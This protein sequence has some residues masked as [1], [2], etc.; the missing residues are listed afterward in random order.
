MP[1]GWRGWWDILGGLVPASGAVFAV[2]RTP[3][4]STCFVVSGDSLPRPR[5]RRREQ[6]LGGWWRDQLAANQAF[7]VMR[8]GAIQ[9]AHLFVAGSD[10]KTLPPRGP[11][12]YRAAGEAG[13]PHRRDPTGRRVT[14]VSRAPNKLDAFISARRSLRLRGRWREQRPLGRM[15]ADRRSRGRYRAPVQW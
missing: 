10:S 5:R 15:M 7:T 11:R 3:T 1:G 6:R 13:G 12:T 2:A 4:S 14:P 8:C 9:Q